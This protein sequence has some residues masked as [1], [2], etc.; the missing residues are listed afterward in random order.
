MPDLQLLASVEYGGYISPV[1]LGIFVV[2]FFCWLWLLGWVNRDAEAIGTK[3]DFWTA[4]ILGAGAVAAIIWL[5]VPLFIVG[6][7]F[8]LIAVGATSIGYVTHRNAKVADHDK[9]MTA[10]HIKGL[11]SSDK[12]SID[13][14]KGFLFIT[15]NNNEV[16]MPDAKTPDYFGYKTAC[17]FF[18]DA[19][20][21][22]TDTII[23]LPAAQSYSVT[24]YVDGAALKQPAIDKQQMEYLLHFIK[25]LADLDTKEKRKPQKGTFSI[26]QDNE[27]TDWEVS[28]AGSTAGEQVRIKHL[29]KAGI[30]RLAEINLTS[31]Q[32][33]LLSKIHDGQKGLF[34]ISGPQKSGVTSTLYSLLRNH[35]A[36]LNSIETLERQPSVDLPNITQ[37]SFTLSDTGTTSYGKKLQSVVRMG[38]DI[39]GVADCQD[40]ETAQVACAAA[41]SGKL[42]YVTLKADSAAQAMGKWIKLVGDK[43]AAVEP[44][45]GIINQRLLRKLC[46][47]CKQ[48]YT[49][50]KELLRKFNLPP[51]KAKVLYRPGKVQ[52]DKH[53]K[54]RPCEDCQEIGFVGRMGIF[55]LVTMNEQLRNAVQQS[56]S[57]SEISAHFRNARMVGLQQQALKEAISG[58]TAINEIVRVFST[59]RK[60]RV[61]KPEQ[62]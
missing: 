48:G 3:A 44:L 47:G 37:H 27:G 38:P 45:F 1:K 58:T 30:K 2:L 18:T 49:P 10:E 41:K 50:N 17:D 25:N 12:K 51:D 46:E 39:V 56:N 4:V 22:R 6:I 26:R 31:E 11:F 55:E 7:L 29:A 62:K 32:Y 15:A 9:V 23:L 20:W 36:F 24:Y 43:K 5:V 42:I 34:I 8:Y 59:S 13:S 40:A 53:G 16:P 19:I 28:T 60:Q 54:P 14:I 33:G 61:K 57:S 35:D 52:L 21:R